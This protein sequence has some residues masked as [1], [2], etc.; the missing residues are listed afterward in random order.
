MI[1]F[2][3]KFL[4]NL[5]PPSHICT[6]FSLIHP[7]VEAKI[8]PSFMVIL[9]KTQP[10]FHKG[11]KRYVKMPPVLENFWVFGQK[12]LR[13]RKI[14]LSKTFNPRI[15]NVS[16]VFLNQQPGLYDLKCFQYS[17]YIDFFANWEKISKSKRNCKKILVPSDPQYCLNHFKPSTGIRSLQL[18]ML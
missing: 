12:T 13:N 8:C 1:I 11:D 17:K 6:P 18:E 9:K 3:I 4:T 5:S 16:C 2:I 15:Y 7:F 10:L 14:N